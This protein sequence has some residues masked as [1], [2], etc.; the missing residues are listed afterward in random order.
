MFA[1]PA[2]RCVAFKFLR[3]GQA[4]SWL[5]L[6]WVGCVV[7]VGLHVT[8]LYFDFLFPFSSFAFIF[9][10][11]VVPLFLSALFQKFTGVLGVEPTGTE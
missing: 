3:C 11:G 2:S 5:A 9:T 4:S 10:L 6:V 8:T 1:V 7:G